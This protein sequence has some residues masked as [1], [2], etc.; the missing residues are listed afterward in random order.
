M[1]YSKKKHLQSNIPQLKVKGDD[2][3]K[4]VPAEHRVDLTIQDKFQGKKHVYDDV[5]AFALRDGQFMVVLRSNPE[6]T[7]VHNAKELKTVWLHNDPFAN[8]AEG[9]KDAD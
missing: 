7:Y 9:E 1:N 5:Q 4:F 3:A 8:I 6:Y 2:Y